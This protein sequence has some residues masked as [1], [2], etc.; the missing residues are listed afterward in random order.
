MTP[1]FTD[2]QPL[3]SLQRRGAVALFCIVALSRLW[4][5][6]KTIW[7]WDEVLL[8]LGMREFDVSAHH[9]HPPGFPVFIA[10]GKLL[11]PLVESDFR[12][13]QTVNLFAAVLLAPALFHLTRELGFRFRTAIIATAVAA[14]LPNVWFYGGTAFSDISSLAASV[15]G[16]GLLLSGRRNRSHYWWGVIAFAIAAGIRPQTILLAPLPFVLAS[17]DRARTRRWEPLAALVVGAAIVAGVYAAAA[18]ATGSWSKFQSAIT[19]HASYIQTIDSFR[20]PSRPGLG[21]IFNAFFFKQYA[22]LATGYLITL[23]VLISCASAARNRSRP[24]GLA[25][26]LF[27]P[28]CLSAALMLDRFSVSR[29]AVGYSPLFAIMFAHGLGVASGWLPSSSRGRKVFEYSMASATIVWMT[30]WF[31]PSLQHVR[32]ESSPSFSAVQWIRSNLPISQST[33]FV[34]TAM[35]PFR[36]YF[37]PDYRYEAI[38]DES[39]LPLELPKQGQGWILAE[40]EDD[41]APAR[42]TRPK[43]GPLWK[44]ARR[45]YFETFVT[46]AESALELSEEWMPVERE[47]TRLW[48][49]MGS[50]G[51]IELSSPAP[52]SLLKIR[53]AGPQ[54]T[55]AV[56]VVI[57]FNGVELDRFV[58]PGWE[59]TREYKVSSFTDGKKNRLELLSDTTT[60]DEQGRLVGLRLY[61][62]S[63]RAKGR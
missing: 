34:A 37:L 7:E 36:E 1:S 40:G 14:F 56:N 58:A 49:A 28:F 35:D 16:A 26:L 51:T 19:H 27:A 63:F 29:Y 9:P 57:R 52:R 55:D 42:F 22:H 11:R 24:V 45:R 54:W 44:T 53:L 10:L 6:S 47:G 15:G 33:L 8:C 50:H 5:R 17:I 12:A 13:L 25:L 59:I 60:P 62:V 46:K 39:S 61:S 32:S 43:K 21:S 31:I 41:R 30:A 48:R 3:N 2:P 23:F 18:G 4:A 38:V 20:S